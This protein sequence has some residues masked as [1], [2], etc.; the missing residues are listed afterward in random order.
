ME[1][2]IIKFGDIKIETQKFHQDKRPIS[3]KN[4]DIDKIV[5]AN[6]VSFL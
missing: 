1:K 6:K 5:V 4:T 2:T 3:I